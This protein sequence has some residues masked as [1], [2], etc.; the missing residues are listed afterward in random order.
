MDNANSKEYLDKIRSAVIEN[1]RKTT[2][3]PSV[4]MTDVPR[5]GLAMNDEDEAALDD[6]DEDENPDRRLT[7]RRFDKRVEKN[8]ELSDSE[9]E[10]MNES[11]GI[12]KQFDAKRRRAIQ[13]FRGIQDVNDSGV[14]S[15]VGT[16]QAG[17]SLP[18]VDEDT[19]MDEAANEEPESRA[20]PSPAM[21]ANGSAN[22]STAQSPQPTA[23]EDVAMGDAPAADGGAPPPADDQPGA[24][25]EATPPESPILQQAAPTTAPVP[26]STATQEPESAVAAV[27]EEMAAEDAAVV[28]EA[29]GIQEREEANV[30]GEVR[31][32]AV[33]KAEEP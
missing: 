23:D 16:P 4:Q 28:A 7:Q 6:L 27:K 20:T 5:D 2:F 11:N 14:D 18:D 32:E 21:V 31:T 13:N 25:Q 33:A 9:D 15:G 30:D 26:E 12:R 29:E 17:S 24:I 8:G 1:L 19:N 3:A 10:E 22:V